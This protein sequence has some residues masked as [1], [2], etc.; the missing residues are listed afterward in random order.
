[1]QARRGYC[2]TQSILNSPCLRTR[3]QICSLPQL[4]HFIQS[5]GFKDKDVLT[6]RCQDCYFQRIDGRWF[7]FCRTHPRHKQRQ[8]IDEKSKWI[9]TH[10]THG[11]KKF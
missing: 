10:A 6:K 7:V 9:I 1:M 5:R 3:E 2:V 4:P 11:R 8:R